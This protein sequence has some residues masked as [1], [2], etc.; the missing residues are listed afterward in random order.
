M[1]VNAP[2]HT[3]HA[4]RAG[5][6]PARSAS[7]KPS[8]PTLA[9]LEFHVKVEAQA[10]RNCT[11]L[12]PYAMIVHHASPSLI[13]AIACCACGGRP[14]VRL[15]RTLSSQRIR[16]SSNLA[17][18]AAG[19]SAYHVPVLRDECV[20]W[21]ITDASGVYV[22]AT[23]GGGGH[24]EEILARLA[25]HNGR[26][27]SCDRDSDAIKT[28][29]RRLA[30]YVESGTSTLLHT[31]FAN[32]RRVLPEVPVDGIL[33]DLGVSSHQIDEG[34]RGFSFRTDGPLDMRMRS[35]ERRVGKECRS[36]WSPYH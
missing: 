2:S 28:A 9:I 20:D 5:R 14:S 10:I 35:E 4:A 24:S 8:A 25:P 36:R 3:P 11:V 15:A 6:T 26:L 16:L 23:L 32:L 31:S 34:S 1:R 27:F 29:R 17:N 19:G 13:A 21:L 12:L 18:V 30:P 33:L 7:D 22:D